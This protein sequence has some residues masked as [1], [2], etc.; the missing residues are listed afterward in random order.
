MSYKIFK[1]EN[2]VN[3]MS[4]YSVEINDSRTMLIK[5]SSTATQSDIDTHIDER[6]ASE[7]A[8]LE[9]IAKEEA[10]ARYALEHSDG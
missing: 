5:A 7:N 3:N 6:L 9:Y 4:Y 8:H 1:T 10:D 2:T